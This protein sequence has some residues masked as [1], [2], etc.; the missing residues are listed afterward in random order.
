VLISANAAFHRAGEQ[1][2][3][4]HVDKRIENIFL[5]TKLHFAFDVHPDEAQALA[6]FSHPQPKEER[7]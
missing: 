2:K 5:I 7:R 3:M 6:D 1:M 4:C